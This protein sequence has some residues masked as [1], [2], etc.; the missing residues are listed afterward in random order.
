M[1][2]L[3]FF[4]HQ[5]SVVS[6]DRLL[7]SLH[8]IVS[9][10]EISPNFCIRHPNYKPL[11]LPAEMVERFQRV[12]LELQNKYLNLQ[13]RG[14]LY[15]I[16]YNGS[17]H[18]TL[19]PDA[20]AVDLSLHQDLANNTVLGVDPEFYNRLHTSNKGEGY[21]DGGWQVIKQESDGTLAVSK[22]GLTL[23]IEPERHLE[24]AQRSAT[25]GDVVAIRMPRN[26]VQNGFYI[27]VSNVGVGDNLNPNSQTVRIYFNLTPKGAIAVMES[28][29]EQLNKINIP[30]TFKVLYNPADYKRYDSGVLYFDKSNYERIRSVLET[31]YANNQTNFKADVPLFTKL[32]APGLALAE[33]PNIKFTA[34]ESFGMNRCQIVANGLLQAQHQGDESLE[35]RMNSILEQFSL[36]GIN[37][38]HPYLN[39]N[40]E[41][42]YTPLTYVD[43]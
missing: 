30:F 20:D 42:I 32:I 23:H 9:N 2:V 26:L 22:G 29:T 4:P 38:Q 18:S 6:S 12:P 16:Y 27:A 43:C 15:G 35:N 24:S 14:F 17:L 8:D 31:V 11:E 7:A 3:D 1:Q 10:V 33:E 5:Q 36:L 19:A 25:V 28:L 13:L 37:W 39:A 34:Q 40:S 41:D 21:F